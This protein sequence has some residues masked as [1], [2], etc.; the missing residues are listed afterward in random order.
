MEFTVL[1]LVGYIDAICNMKTN[2]NIEN[3]QPENHD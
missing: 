2:E 3:N 1:S